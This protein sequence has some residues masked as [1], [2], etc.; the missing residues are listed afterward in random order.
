MGIGEEREEGA[1]ERGEQRREG[2]GE[3]PVQQLLRRRLRQQQELR[4]VL[5]EAVQRRQRWYQ[6]RVLTTE[7]PSWNPYLK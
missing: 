7:Q 3:L 4:H 2:R 6:I 1:E 5:E